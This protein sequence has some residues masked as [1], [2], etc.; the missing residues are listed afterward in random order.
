MRRQV[1]WPGL[2]DWGLR[3][4]DFISQTGLPTGNQWAARLGQG[5][6]LTILP[7]VGLAALSA[8]WLAAIL[9]VYLRRRDLIYAAIVIA[10]LVLIVLAAA[11][12]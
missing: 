3:S 10:Q 9:P 5:D 6:V 1:R 8:V 4:S 2:I 7:G 12:L 11:G